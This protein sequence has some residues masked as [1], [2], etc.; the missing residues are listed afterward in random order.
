[1]EFFIVVERAG[2]NFS[3][4]SPDI[5]GCVG[6]GD[7]IEE[8]VESMKQSIE[9]ALEECLK[10]DFPLPEPKGMAH[11]IQSKQFEFEANAFFTTI[12]VEVPQLA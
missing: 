1:M 2:A 7:T 11:H 3:S 9:I 12:Y 6:I 8:T 4:Y 10:N 5:R